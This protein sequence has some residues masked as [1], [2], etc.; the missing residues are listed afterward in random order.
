MTNLAALRDALSKV[1]CEGCI[2]LSDGFP[3]AALGHEQRA[4][5]GGDAKSAAIAAA[6]VIAKET[7]DR[8]MR[9]ADAAHPGGS[10]PSTS[11]TPRPSTA[12]RSS[13]SASRR[14]TGCSFQSMAYQQLSLQAERGA[15]ASGRAALRLERALEVLEADAAAR[16]ASNVTPIASNRSASARGRSVRSISQRPAI[17]RTCA[18]L[19]GVHRLERAARRPRSTRRVLTSQNA[20]VRPSNATMSSSPQRVR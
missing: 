3:V 17:L 2:C 5:I 14:C 18:R 10:S 20:S 19:R 11:A 9:R 6:S 8:Y 1:A 12:R 7:R 13:G 16:R 15:S 4:V